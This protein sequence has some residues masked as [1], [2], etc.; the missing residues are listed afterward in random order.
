MHDI[1]VYFPKFGHK[2]VHAYNYYHRYYRAYYSGDV[3][4]C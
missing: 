4:Y 1:S 2:V 3:I